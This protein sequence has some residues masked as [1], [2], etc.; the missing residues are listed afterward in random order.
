MKRTVKKTAMLLLMVCLLFLPAQHAEAARKYPRRITLNKTKITAVVGTSRRLTV[1]TTPKTVK[2]SS[3]VWSSSNEAVATVNKKRQGDGHRNRNGK[4]HCRHSKRK[5]SD[6][7]RTRKTVHC[8]QWKG[9]YCDA[10][11]RKNV[12]GI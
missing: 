1:T 6:L 7:H 2:N 8:F 4:D 12:S 11:R 3:V 9:S 10:G 5:K